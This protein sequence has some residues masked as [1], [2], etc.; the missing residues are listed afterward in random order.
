MNST[1][2]PARHLHLDIELDR[3]NRFHYHSQGR[4]GRRV[5]LHRGDHIT[6]TCGEDFSIRFI[7]KSPFDQTRLHAHEEAILRSHEAFITSRVRDDAPDGEYPYVVEVTR[8]QELLRD[9]PAIT[10]ED[11]A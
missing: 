9:S 10:V 8:D 1:A 2:A 7:K 4:D 3:E 5:S 6:F 11:T